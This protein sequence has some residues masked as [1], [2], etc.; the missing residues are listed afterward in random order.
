MS[1]ILEMDDAMKPR[2]ELFF[3]LCELNMEFA[4]CGVMLDYPQATPD[5]VTRI[6]QQRL[7]LH[8]LEKWKGKGMSHLIDKNLKQSLVQMHDF[9]EAHQFQ[10]ALTGGMALAVW[11]QPR[12]TSDVGIIIAMAAE[13]APMLQK[14]IKSPEFAFEADEL[15]FPHMK[16]IRAHLHGETKQ[17]LV[18]IDFI[19]VG[20]DWSNSI[21]QR[22]QRIALAEQPIWVSS[23]EDIL[24]LKLFSQR[25]KDREDIQGIL[26]Q[27]GSLLDQAY[28][29]GMDI[30]ARH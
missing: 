24:L 5:E 28:L 27:R 22:C 23:A 13:D 3:E 29:Q 12:S 1:K 26:L 11:G 15:I 8:R 10:Y 17:V 9:L 14:L 16:I 7:D 2:V 25:D 21:M 30:E 4:R 19:L 6:L 18:T 20:H